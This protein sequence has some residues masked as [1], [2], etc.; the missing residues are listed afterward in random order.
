MT[1]T[2]WKVACIGECMIELRERPDG[3]LSRAFGGDTLNT[4]IY[5]ARVGGPGLAVDYVTALGDDAHSEE[6]LRAW[7]AEGV[8]TGLVPRLPGR[9]PGLYL[10]QTD[11]K[12]ERRFS[13][14]RGEAPVRQLFDLPETPDIEAGLAAADLVYLSGITLSLFAGAA[15]ERLFGALQAVRAAGGRVVFDSNFRPRG[16]PDPE[17]ARRAFARAIALSHTVLAGVEDFA[18]LEDGAT[19]EA[20]VTRLRDAGVAEAV[21]KRPEPG[22]IVLCGDREWDVP[23]PEPV[24]PVDTTAA[25]DSFAAAFLAARLAGLPPDAAALAGHRLAGAV[26]RHPGAIIPREAMPSGILDHP[27]APEAA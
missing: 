14:W 16:W 8:G 6:M 20:L 10:I 2:A 7:E 1:R 4:A 22:C 18:L 26:I 11:A 15:R 23:P 27:D 5:L 24:T 21:V 17:E 12:G 9:V 25:G 13:Y 3:L 19:P